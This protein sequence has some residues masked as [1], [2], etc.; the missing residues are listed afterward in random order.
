VGVYAKIAFFLRL[1]VGS[2]KEKN[3]N[4]LG[5]KNRKYFSGNLPENDQRDGQQNGE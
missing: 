5:I 3:I 1:G 2:C 4:Y